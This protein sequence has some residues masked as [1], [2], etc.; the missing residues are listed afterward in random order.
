MVDDKDD[1]SREERR[2]QKHKEKDFD[3]PRVRQCVTRIVCSRFSLSLVRRRTTPTTNTKRRLFIFLFRIMI[4]HV[5]ITS[6]LF[7]LSLL[8]HQMAPSIRAA[9]VFGNLAKVN[10]RAILGLKLH[11]DFAKHEIFDTADKQKLQKAISV[12]RKER[13]KTAG[14]VGRSP[15][16]SEGGSSIV[17][18]SSITTDSSL[19][20]PRNTHTHATNG[21]AAK[22]P[23][24]ATG[25]REDEFERSAAT[26][27]QKQQQDKHQI[28]HQRKRTS[29]AVVAAPTSASASSSSRETTTT[30][31]LTSDNSSAEHLASM[32]NS[33]NTSAN[34]NENVSTWQKNNL[35]NMQRS[36][37][38]NTDGN[39]TSKSDEDDDPRIRV[40]VRARPLAPREIAKN[41]RNVCDADPDF[42]DF[43]R[44]RTQSKSRSDEIY[45]NERVRI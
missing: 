26:A 6:F 22:T 40:V 12:L 29:N 9:K 21:G 27:T 36:K 44:L 8:V 19:S 42:E 18:S 13:S 14:T 4:A 28:V 5:S 20:S 3:P 11:P 25:A 24:N 10:E 2:Q 45:G 1:A 35:V 41:E 31:S 7:S 34:S 15:R 17:S 32:A 16:T 37:N 30:T 43:D 23:R 33:S 38:N 39:N